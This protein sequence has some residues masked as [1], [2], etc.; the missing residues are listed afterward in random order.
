MTEKSDTPA[1]D[2]LNS[3]EVASPPRRPRWL[4]AVVAGGS[5]A[6]LVA[7]ALAGSRV[8][9]WWGD[10][11]P[12]AGPQ[13]SHTPT[14]P[15][16]PFAGTPAEDFAEGA[17]GI[18]LPEAEAVGDFTADEVADA[19]EQVREALIAARL[20]PAVLV[21]HDLEPFLAALASDQAS[22]VQAAIEA[23]GYG[24]FPT[25]VA[26]GAVLAPEQPRVEGY[27]AYEAATA[28]PRDSPIINVVSRFVWVYPFDPFLV[29]I[30]DELI[31][32]VAVVRPWIE[33]SR[34]VWLAD[35][36]ANAWGVDC[37]YQRGTLRPV[38]G[39]SP[40]SAAVFNLEQPVEPSPGC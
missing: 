27:I 25:L 29:V 12:A 20:D 11:E 16:D 13:P 4:V 10:D 36:T 22:A 17:D 8:L 32:E 37:D 18:V 19:L 1:A 15:V 39:A 28:G 3:T 33:S 30:R 21:D 31:W 40:I 23:S 2:D 38:D 5:A 26:S 35:V 14:E 6:V 24:P 9:G 7:A 34:G